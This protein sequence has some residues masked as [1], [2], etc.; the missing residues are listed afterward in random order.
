MKVNSGG[1][2]TRHVPQRTCV[3]CRK[4]G[5]KRDLVRLVCVPEKGVEIDLTR[6]KPGRGAYLCPDIKCW[7]QALKTGRLEQALKAS[8][9]AEEKEALI[10]YARG[11]DKVQQ[12]SS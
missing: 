2:P 11:F 5:I 8:L 10:N 1:T 4:V 12:I 3:F 6:K 7:E 9:K